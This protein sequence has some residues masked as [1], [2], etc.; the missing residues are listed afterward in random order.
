MTHFMRPENGGDR[1]LNGDIHHQSEET[2]QSYQHEQ[3]NVPPHRVDERYA[4]Q[5]PGYAPSWNAPAPHP[6][7]QDE[8]YAAPYAYGSARG[9]GVWHNTQPN[10]L[11]APP[12]NA[13]ASYVNQEFGNV[14]NAFAY[15]NGVPA[16]TEAH[17]PF[18][19]VGSVPRLGAANVN[20]GTGVDAQPHAPTSEGHAPS[21]GLRSLARHYILDP[22]TRV[23][24][25]RMVSDGCGRL[26]MYITLEAADVV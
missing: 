1:I 8:H 12:P 13:A 25:V 20:G 6:G 22:R 15:G 2:S 7:Y 5:H 17:G 26:N 18:S 16:L 23:Y 9:Y 11:F 21:E 14:N 19:A 4:A 10:V 24:I 3:V